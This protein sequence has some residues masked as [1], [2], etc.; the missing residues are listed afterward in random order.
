MRIADLGLSYAQLWNHLHGHRL[1]YRKVPVRFLCDD[2]YWALLA[3]YILGDGDLARNSLV[4]FYDDEKATLMAIRE[5]FSKR[6]GYLFPSPVYEENQYGRGQWVIRTRHAA[7]HF[8][9][10]EYFDIP[11]GRKKLTSTLSRRIMAT[12][13]LEVKYAA[14]AGM[15]SSDGHVSSYRTDQRFLGRIGVLSTVSP[16]KTRTVARMLREIGYHPYVSTTTFRNPLTGRMTTAFR[17]VVQR[18]TEVV[19]LFF[20]LFPYLVKSARSKRWMKLMADRDFYARLRVH[21]TGIHAVL[22]RAAM[23]AASSSYRYLHVLVKIARKYGITVDRAG[24]IKRWTSGHTS[25]APLPVIV[26]CC[27][28]LRENVLDHVPAQLAPL[29][30]LHGAIGYRTLVTLRGVKPVLSLDEM[31]AAC[32]KPSP[33]SP[34]SVVR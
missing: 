15:L 5:L 27:K 34:L 24:G 8:V 6:F 14:L 25:S 13:N 31:A 20:R 19:D 29:L 3:S 16:S 23:K 17:I 30:W 32:V 9:F 21:S 1:R 4:R 33:A 2:P 12:N 10:A 18:R 26:E 7:I 22:R 11:I 28:I